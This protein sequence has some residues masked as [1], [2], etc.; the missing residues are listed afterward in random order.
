MERDERKT[1]GQ[2]LQDIEEQRKLDDELEEGLEET[3]PG[4]D[5]VNVVQPVKEKPAERKVWWR[6]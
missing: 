4:S 6:D 1:R 3:F 5:P 2:S